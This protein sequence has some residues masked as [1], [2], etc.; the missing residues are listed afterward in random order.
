MALPSSQNPTIY[1]LVSNSKPVSDQLGSGHARTG[2][3][4]RI[5][6]WLVTWRTSSDIQAC[7]SDRASTTNPLGNSYF[8]PKRLMQRCQNHLCRSL[9]PKCIRFK[10]RPSVSCSKTPN[11]GTFSAGSA[12]HPVSTQLLTCYRP[13]YLPAKT[14]NQLLTRLEN[15]AI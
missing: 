9:V 15:L 7:M 4:H 5:P 12:P 11:F 2:L 8:V 1:V 13:S 3:T 10:R 14:S 6:T